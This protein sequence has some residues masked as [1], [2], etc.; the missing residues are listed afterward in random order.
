MC[1]EK[2]LRGRVILSP[3][4]EKRRTRHIR[5]MEREDCPAIEQD[6][7]LPVETMYQQFLLDFDAAWEIYF[8]KRIEVAGVITRMGPDP[9]GLPSIEL[10]D[11]SEGRCY[12][13]CIA[14]T[15]ELYEGIALGDAVIC[16]GNL[17]NA[18]EPYGAVMKKSEITYITP[19]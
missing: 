5:Q 6:T 18:R 16:R 14:G 10:S 13:L 19:K 4:Q 12:A 17:I 7:P 15:R 1:E 11:R 9:H 8:A 2:G 3:E